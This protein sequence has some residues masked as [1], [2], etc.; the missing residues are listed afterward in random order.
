[1][2]AACSCSGGHPK[3]EHAAAAAPALLELTQSFYAG[4]FV[5]PKRRD[6]DTYLVIAVGRQ[7]G[8]AGNLGWREASIEALVQPVDQQ[9]SAGSRSEVC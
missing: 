3:E 4:I 7:K 9:A 1:M 8:L 5:L 6:V 2:A